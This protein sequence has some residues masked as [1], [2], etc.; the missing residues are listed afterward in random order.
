MRRF[1]SRTDL[2]NDIY[3]ASLKGREEELYRTQWLYR[4]HRESENAFDT[5]M[6]FLHRFE[7]RV[8]SLYR[9]HR[10]S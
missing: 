4:L 1:V 9:I 8:N 5:E 2:G 3:Y 7:M 10:G 6:A